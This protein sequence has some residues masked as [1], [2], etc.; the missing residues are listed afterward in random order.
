MP[1]THN[2][3]PL[4]KLRLPIQR[5]PIAENSKPDHCPDMDNLLLPLLNAGD[6]QERQR[7]VEALLTIH[8]AAIIRQVLRQRLG[9]Y[10]SAQG[11]NKNNHDAEDLYQDAMARMIEVLHADPRSL[12]TIENLERYVGRVVSNVCVD[13]LR[14][15]YPTRVRLKN[16]VR[17]IFRR[18]EDLASWQIDDEIVCGF[19][20]WQDTGRRAAGAHDVDTKLNAFLS[21]RFADEDVRVVPLSRVMTELFHWLAGPVQI[22]VL[23]SMLAYIRDVREPQAESFDGDI[24]SEHLHASTWSTES[25]LETHELLGRLWPLVKQL[26]PKQRCVFAFGF[27]DQ[28]GRNLFSVLLAAGIVDLTDLAEGMGRSEADVARL[29]TQMPMDTP[30]IASE[31]HTSRANVYRLRYRAIRQLKAELR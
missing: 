10:V 28:A 14:S 11:V 30:T 23:V 18:H 19:A 24:A 29:W 5:L 21:S 3:A 7:R 26:T 2:P 20:A 15:K 31:L 12:A 25:D 13:F 22:D 27:Q 1:S 9:F 6:E 4:G 8:I 17:D 16:A